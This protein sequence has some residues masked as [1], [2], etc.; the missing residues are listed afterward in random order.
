[1]FKAHTYYTL[2]AM[3]AFTL[4]CWSLYHFAN[5]MGDDRPPPKNPRWEWTQGPGGSL[6]LGAG[7]IAI[8]FWLFNQIPKAVVTGMLT[9]GGYLLIL[10]SFLVAQWYFWRAVY[11]WLDFERELARTPERRAV[12]G[13]DPDFPKIGLFALTAFM[14]IV[15]GDMVRYLGR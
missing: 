14:L 6:G 7:G 8:G 9:H 10:L 13:K 3:L 11:R 2:C 15:F 12:I 4:V 1:M 5:R